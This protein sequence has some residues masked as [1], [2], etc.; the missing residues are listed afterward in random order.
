[1]VFFPPSIYSIFQYSTFKQNLSADLT[2]VSLKS[3]HIPDIDGLGMIQG[4][5]RDIQDVKCTDHICTKYA[6]ISFHH[7]QDWGLCLPY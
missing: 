6:T 2:L 7:L 5:L 1:M 3:A 4:H